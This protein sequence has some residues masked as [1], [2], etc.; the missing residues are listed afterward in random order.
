M[1]RWASPLPWALALLAVGALMSTCAER[2]DSGETGPQVAYGTQETA[3][4]LPGTWLR[5]YREEGVQVRRLLV[6]QAKG[7]FRE[8][9]R[10]VGTDGRVQEFVNEGTWLY[11]GTNL[12]RRYTSLNGKPPS[13]LNVPFVTFEVRFDSRNDFVGVDHIHDRTIRYERVPSET[14]L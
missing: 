9:S 14:G 6:L 5:E 12:K 2:P 13:R 7:D 10:I 3:E 11:D 1:L 4:L 8:V